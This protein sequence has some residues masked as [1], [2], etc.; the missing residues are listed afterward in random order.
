[1]TER[2]IVM[3]NQVSADGFFSDRAGGL[4]F[5]VSDPEVHR[6]AVASM[7]EA[8][9]VLFGRH[10]YENFAAFWPGA[11]KELKKAGPHGENRADPAF[12]AMAQ[13]L[14]E[15]KKLVASRTLT[16]AE[17]NNSEVVPH[18]DAQTVRALKQRAGKDILVFGSGTVVSQLSAAR[19]IDEYRFVVCPVLL[20]AG[21]S[22]LSGAS[23]ELKLS[24]KEAVALPS[25]N[26]LMTY[27][28]QR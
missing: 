20:G 19:L 7:P 3:F 26:V 8:D 2:R 18:L 23:L 5:I 17:W 10:T 24:L 27:C 28:P 1:M 16:R 13:W 22:L 6:R 21:R 4:G 25:G 9:T 14:N 15:S 12:V 11:L